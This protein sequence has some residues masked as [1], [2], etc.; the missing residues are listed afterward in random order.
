MSR[1]D[2]QARFP[3]MDWREPMPTRPGPDG[4]QRFSC[5]IC[6]GEFSFNDGDPP[7]PSMTYD[8]AIEHIAKAHPKP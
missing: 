1:I 6:F 7:G 8:E 5:C 2:F 4:V 3:W